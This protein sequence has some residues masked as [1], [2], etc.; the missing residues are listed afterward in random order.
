MHIVMEWVD[1]PHMHGEAKELAAIPPATDMVQ[2]A[3]VTLYWQVLGIVPG[4]GPMTPSSVVPNQHLDLHIHV[5]Q[6][7]RFR[8]KNVPLPVCFFAFSSPDKPPKCNTS[9]YNGAVRR[10]CLWWEAMQSHM[11]SQPVKSLM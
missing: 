7:L 1:N 9:N 4:N 2:L 5:Q 3:L 11:I 8:L 6:I 10:Y